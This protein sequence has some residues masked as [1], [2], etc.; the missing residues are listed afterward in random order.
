MTNTDGPAAKESRIIYFLPVIAPLVV[1]A[2]FFVFYKGFLFCSATNPCSPLSAAEIL[3]G[4]SN[5][6]Q[7]RVAAYVARAT[8]T[9]VNGVHLLACL[10]AIV[11]AGVVIDHALMP[12]YETKVRWLIILI[13]VALALDVSLLVAWWTAGDVWSPAQQL[14]RATVGQKVPGI[15]K[16]N[17]LA[18]ALSLGGTLSLAAAA[19]ATLWQRHA[20]ADEDEQQLLKRVRLL[21]PV[22]IVGAVTLVIAILRLSVT[23]AWG[24]SFLPP[25][26]A[27]AKNLA[28]LITGIVGSLGTVYTLLMAALYLPAAIILRA[29]VM[30]LATTQQDPQ[31]WL[32][33]NGLD[34]SISKVVPRVIALLAPLLAGPLGDLLVRATKDLGG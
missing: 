15:N 34:L 28:S 25:D 23:H 14:L 29:R 13:V 2:T 5:S 3:A 17:R 27:L 20:G 24:A 19:C 18:E 9:L 33:N 32:S 1:I 11:T 10:V 21:R 22:L 30:K 12:E 16:Y 8:W 31:T 7:T 26:S 4:V 6:D